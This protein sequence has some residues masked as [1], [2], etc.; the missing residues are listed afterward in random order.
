VQ[1]APPPVL[2][3]Y[4]TLRKGVNTMLAHARY[5]LAWCRGGQEITTVLSGEKNK[6]EGESGVRIGMG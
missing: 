2:L 1:R 6:R 5:L 3:E 4:L